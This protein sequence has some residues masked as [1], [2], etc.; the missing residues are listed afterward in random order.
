MDLKA[1]H[2]AGK[3]PKFSMKVSGG[4]AGPRASLGKGNGI[5]RKGAKDI[6]GGGDGKGL[7]IADRLNMSMEEPSA[8]R[9]TGWKRRK[10]LEKVETLVNTTECGGS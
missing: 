4:S 1:V 2:Y 6:D 7:H 9:P 10:Q 5:H 3:I 8:R